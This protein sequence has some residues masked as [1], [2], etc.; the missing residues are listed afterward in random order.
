LPMMFEVGLLIFGF[1]HVGLAIESSMLKKIEKEE[2]F[3]GLAPKQVK[4]KR[5]DDWVDCELSEIKVDDVIQISPSQVIPLDGEVLSTDARVTE[6]YLTGQDGTRLLSQQEVILAGVQLTKDSPLLL[7][8]VKRTVADSYLATMDEV[9]KRAYENQAPTQEKTARALMYFVPIVILIAVL[10]GLFVG[11]FVGVGLAISCAIAVLLSAC[12][13][14]LGLVWSLW[15]LIGVEK[16]GRHGLILASGD[17]LERA[18]NIDTVVFDLNGTLTEGPRS[19]TIAWNTDECSLDAVPRNLGS[20]PPTHEQLKAKAIFSAMETK[21]IKMKQDEQ[22]S[23]EWVASTAMAEVI[24]TALKAPPSLEID[25]DQ[26]VFEPTFAGG[27]S[28]TYEGKKWMIGNATFM[29]E[30]GVDL[31]PQPAQL[32]VGSQELWMACDHSP[33]GKIILQDT[34][35]ADAEETILHLMKL[36]K[37]VYLCTGA[38]YATAKRYADQLHIPAEHIYADCMPVQPS[39][40]DEGMTKRTSK[41]QHIQA[42]QALGHRVAFVG[43]GFN[44][45][46]VSVQSNLGIAM[47]HAQTDVRTKQNT[48]VHIAGSLLKPLAFLFPIAKQT[49]KWIKLSLGLS[50]GYNLISI[51]FASG[52]LLAAGVV[53]NPVIGAVLMVVQLALLLLAA[54]IIHRKPVKLP[55]VEKPSLETSYQQMASHGLDAQASN[56]LIPQQDEV[57]GCNTETQHAKN[58][59]ETE[60]DL[61]VNPLGRSAI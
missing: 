46:A 51:L 20:P 59:I 41:L 55:P 6:K 58:N 27:L 29:H 10:S 37:K 60:S 12:P 18:K 57:L 32:D 47:L 25:L 14:T 45:A 56:G 5:G 28:A 8:K 30:R 34:L 36:K 40:T 15:V 50:L 23:G 52:V 54:Y 35:R 26:L 31:P 21:V 2:S 24:L 11:L 16:A 17:A 13:C 42:L 22:T 61:G 39:Q 48:Q 19:A 3:Q 4:V 43:D 53:L 38:N 7:L 44:D 9:T 33:I 1:R 49:N